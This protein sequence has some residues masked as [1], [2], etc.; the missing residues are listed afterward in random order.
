MA[1]M[2]ALCTVPIP[3]AAKVCADRGDLHVDGGHQTSGAGLWD[4]D[5]A[6]ALGREVLP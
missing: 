1:P 2:D 6:G 5:G 4:V 3:A